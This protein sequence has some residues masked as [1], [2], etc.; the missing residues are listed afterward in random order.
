MGEVGEIEPAIIT[1]ISPNGGEIL[2]IGRT[3][4]I[5]WESTLPAAGNSEGN[6]KAN[7]YLQVGPMSGTQCTLSGIC[8]SI[9]GNQKKIASAVF[10]AD[11]KYSWTIP[12]DEVVSS[13]CKIYI[14]TINYNCFNNTCLSDTSDNYFSIEAAS[15]F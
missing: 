8:C 15:N 11:N 9:C 6:E 10:I 4:D 2:Q 1:V 7:I 3:Y 5:T 14:R 13:E 12:N